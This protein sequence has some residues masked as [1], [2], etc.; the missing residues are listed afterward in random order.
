MGNCSLAVIMYFITNFEL[1]NSTTRSGHK[2]TESTGTKSCG[3]WKFTAGSQTV[4]IINL[5]SGR[6]N[7][8]DVDACIAHLRV[9]VKDTDKSGNAEQWKAEGLAD[10]VMKGQ[11][12]S[13]IYSPKADI[14]KSDIQISLIQVNHSWNS[15]SQILKYNKSLYSFRSCRKFTPVADSQGVAL[16]QI[17]DPVFTQMMGDGCSRTCKCD[18]ISQFQSTAYQ[19]TNKTCF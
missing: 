14:L 7:V 6:V 8:V 15:S 17:K 19:H 1:K 12:S 2:A 3:K 5:L 13:N 10:L 18:I 16:E 11:R 4:N 9:T